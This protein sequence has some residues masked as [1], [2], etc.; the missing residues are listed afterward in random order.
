M[1]GGGVASVRGR[2]FDVRG[3]AWLLLLLP[4]VGRVAWLLLLL[5]LLPCV[6]G[7]AWLLLRTKEGS[8]AAC[9]AG[10]ET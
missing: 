4:H 8:A 2:F 3:G 7:I 10:C 6:W 9:E 1:C 5:L